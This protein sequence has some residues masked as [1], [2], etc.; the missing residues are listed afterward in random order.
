[1]I[2][3]S[4]PGLEALNPAQFAEQAPPQQPGPQP[5][6]PPRLAG[7]MPASEDPKAAKD[8]IMTSVRVDSQVGQTCDLSRLA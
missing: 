1:M 4:I 2:G 3:K 7:S 5:P 8:E 6:P